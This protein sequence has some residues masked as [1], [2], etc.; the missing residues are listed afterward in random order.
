[1]L[2]PM[3]A[4]STVATALAAGIAIAGCTV[5]QTEAPALSGPSGLAQV[6]T[7]SATPDTITQNGSSQSV[8]VVSVRGPNGEPVSG[9]QLRVDTL[10]NGTATNFGT[11]S[12]RTVTTG[13]NGTANVV[14]TSPAAPPNGAVFGSCSPSLFSPT[15]PGG[16]VTV[17]ATQIANGFTGGTQTSTVDI[18]LV[19]LEVIPVPGAPT[20][21]FTISTPTNKVV[22]YFFFNA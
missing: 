17:A 3:K 16:C 13:S 5:H 14:F 12:S 7:L 2:S 18:H 8:I 4:F 21:D 22:M 1:M 10:V 6:V 19:P 15:L 11:L 20:A 9:Q